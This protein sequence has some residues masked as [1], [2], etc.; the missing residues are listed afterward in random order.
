MAGIGDNEV[1][2]GNKSCNKGKYQSKITKFKNFNKSQKFSKFQHYYFTF[3][4]N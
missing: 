1:E 4:K 3:E 2:N